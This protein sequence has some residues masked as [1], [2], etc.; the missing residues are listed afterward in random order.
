MEDQKA[1]SHH[2]TS[3]LFLVGAID[4]LILVILGLFFWSSFI[5]GIGWGG[6]MHLTHGADLR[7]ALILSIAAASVWREF[8]AQSRVIALL[9]GFAKILEA[10]KRARW[11]LWVFGLALSL[12]VAALQTSALRYALYDVGIFHQILWSFIHDFGFRST[13]SGAGDF[14]RDHLSPS[15]AL[16]SPI[17]WASDSSPYCLG[18]SMV[19]LISI[20][21]AA[22][23]RLAERI[24][25][26]GS[27]VPAAAALFIVSFD[28]LWA[29]ERWGFHENALYF[30]AMSWA[31]SWFIAP[32]KWTKFQFPLVICLLVAAGSKEILLLNVA[33]FSLIWAFRLKGNRKWIASGLA[34]LFSVFL[35][36]VFI[37]F[38]K[39]PHAEGKNYFLRY[40]SYLGS[41]LGSFASVLFLHPWKIVE[42][43]GAESLFRYF[44]TVFAPWLFLPLLFFFKNP[45]RYLLLAVLLPSF[46]SAALSTY[47]PLRD[48]NFHYVLE[49]WPVLACLT[50]LALNDLRIPKLAWIWACLA[51]LAL[52]QD[53]VA[54]I[55]EYGAGTAL[56]A[57]A[58]AKISEIS[59]TLSVAA[60]ELA[61]P[62]ISSR[63]FVTRYPD[64]HLMPSGC[65][66]VFL[67]HIDTPPRKE[68]GDKTYVESWHSGEWVVYQ[69]G[70]G[71]L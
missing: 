69:E 51:L 15:L 5:G 59:F 7:R 67:L 19:A 35:G 45:S 71:S 34:I 31:V 20:G 66:D 2:N 17:F 56:E 3:I 55:R 57:E 40:Y 64:L 50:I 27:N 4:L 65:P 68:C 63:A 25:E 36:G 24:C 18:F 41:D 33:V 23:L 48:S 22:W 12:V 30:A 62:W 39:L 32:P 1:E 53:P 60:D 43:V 14:F 6:R 49:L 38:E 54:E 47:S 42:A 61:G 28:S 10:S 58:R 26:S 70:K 21:T 8:R 46:M 29:N 9:R 11:S 37:F 44:M 52:D 16:L 13:I